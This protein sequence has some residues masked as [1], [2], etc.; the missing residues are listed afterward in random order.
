MKP[1]LSVLIGLC[2]ASPLAAETF[3]VENGTPRAVIVAEERIKTLK[4]R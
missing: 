3:L 1:L 4:A 2:F